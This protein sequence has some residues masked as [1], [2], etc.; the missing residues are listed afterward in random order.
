MTY[1]RAA[2]TQNTDWFDGI[3]RRSRYAIGLL[4]RYANANSLSS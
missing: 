3:D 2:R 4:P 1:G